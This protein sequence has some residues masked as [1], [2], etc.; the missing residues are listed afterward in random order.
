MRKY[1]WWFDFAETEA[2]AERI[3]SAYNEDAS[4]WQK[5]RY[6]GHYTA[7][8]S[9]EQNAPKYIVWTSR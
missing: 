3:I 1:Q 8:N 2:E 4:A 5:K 7:W 9:K 6:K